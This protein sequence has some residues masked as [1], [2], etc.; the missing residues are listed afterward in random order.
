MSETMIGRLGCMNEK[1]ARPARLRR[2]GP[3]K[4]Q[5]GAAYFFW[6]SFCLITLCASACDPLFAVQLTGP[7]FFC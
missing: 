3:S 5:G 4:P 6:L 2:P 1:Q 7:L